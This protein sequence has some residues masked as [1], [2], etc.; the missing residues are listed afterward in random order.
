MK[1]VDLADFRSRRNDKPSTSLLRIEGVGARDATDFYL[2]K[3]VAYVY[4]GQKMKN[5]TKTRVIWGKVTGS[6]GSSGVVR[7][8]FKRN[9]PPQSFGK[10][11]RVMLYPS[12]V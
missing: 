7:A 4:T 2:G 12:R 10:S 11:A 5:G 8:S 9:L 6:H 3:R 1:C